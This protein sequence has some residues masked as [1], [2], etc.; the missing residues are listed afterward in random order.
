MKKYLTEGIGTFII[1]FVIGAAAGN[2]WIIACTLI[3]LILIG[4]PISGSHYNP[5]VST[6]LWHRGVLS[7]KDMR[8]YILAQVIAAVLVALIF[9]NIQGQN[10]PT[11]PPHNLWNILLIDLIFCFLLNYTILE[12]AA[13]TAK[14]SRLR[15]IIGLV[16]LV[17][18][19]VTGSF[20]GAFFNPA[21][22]L[23]LGMIAYLP[24]AESIALIMTQLLGGFGAAIAFGWFNPPIT[25][26]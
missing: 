3:A 16:V 12:I 20:L 25:Q 14:P 4:L 5:V 13:K 7:N 15:I 24:L 26:D 17:S 22:V 1:I 2:G 6:G 11:H 9:V 21:V 8:G 18:I 19:V 10:A 23:S